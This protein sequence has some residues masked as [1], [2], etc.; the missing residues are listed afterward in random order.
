MDIA[1]FPYVAVPEIYSA[2]EKCPPL[3]KGVRSALDKL[4][5][6]TSDGDGRLNINTFQRSVQA[7][8]ASYQQHRI[9]RDAGA[10]MF[11]FMV[12]LAPV[13][14]A[15]FALAIGCA[16]AYFEGSV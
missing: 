2:L 3:E 13:S 5:T 10:K 9:L 7:N 1:K 15:V 12:V 8:A 14:C 4:V 16:L 6:R 11:C